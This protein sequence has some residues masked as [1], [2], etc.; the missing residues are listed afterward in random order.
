MLRSRD[1]S[2]YLLG[3]LHGPAAFALMPDEFRQMMKKAMRKQI[4]LTLAL[5]AAPLLVS[6]GEVEE[7]F[8]I[9]VGVSWTYH[10]SKERITTLGERVVEERITGESVERVGELSDEFSSELLFTSCHSILQRRIIQQ[11]GKL[12]RPSNRMCLR[13]R[14]RCCS[15]VR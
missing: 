1:A 8:P 5:L 11:D 10:L 4:R 2:S 12:L 13:N 9:N 3:L 15:M 7:Y 6:A 14:I